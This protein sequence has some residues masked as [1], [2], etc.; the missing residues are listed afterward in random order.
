MDLLLECLSGDLAGQSIAISGAEY[1]IGRS[2]SANLRSQLPD[3]SAIHVL[4]REVGGKPMLHVVSSHTTMLNGVALS[5]GDER[6]LAHGMRLT[7]GAQL[8]FKI[9]LQDDVTI[10]S[11]D[12]TV[13]SSPTIVD[14]RTIPPAATPKATPSGA[15]EATLVREP[16]VKTAPVAPQ[17]ATSPSAGAATQFLD[18]SQQTQ[19]VTPEEL[20]QIANRATEKRQR[21][22][23]VY[24][25]LAVGIG[26]FFLFAIASS[27]NEKQK[28][29]DPIPPMKGYTLSAVK[30]DKP[31]TLVRQLPGA[32][33]R[34]RVEFSESPAELSRTR[35]AS[36]AAWM[37]EKNRS[38]ADGE[39]TVDTAWVNRN[40]NL[41]VDE[42]K[43]TTVRPYSLH[44]ALGRGLS[45]VK[46]GYRRLDKDGKI[47]KG[48]AVL[49]RKGEKRWVLTREVD[50]SA[51]NRAGKLFTQQTNGYFADGKMTEEL[52]DSFWDYFILENREVLEKYSLEDVKAL[53]A[54]ARS[55]EGYA[56]WRNIEGAILANLFKTQAETP[57][58]E[59]WESLLASFRAFQRERFWLNP[60]S[61]LSAVERNQAMP[62]LET[63]NRNR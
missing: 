57:Q 6:P 38:K 49:A 26:L 40:G 24:G 30:S 12:A 59:A 5:K 11:N 39:Y 61:T 55:E 52:V 17:P 43:V 56:L 8:S 46:T 19:A 4:L 37:A 20:Q 14:E 18:L 54:R 47:W 41:I 53:L 48:E 9:I 10:V 44:S 1:S 23:K 29:I 63:D 35:A 21:R 32:T 36:M 45:T 31:Y 33:V 28:V 13:I 50:E 34:I 60:V 62:Y 27:A 42:G 2:R 25:I 7:L 16:E 58:R 51:E 3:V 15:P 22:L